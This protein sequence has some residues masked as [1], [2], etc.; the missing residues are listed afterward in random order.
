MKKLVFS[1]LGIVLATTLV[2]PKAASQGPQD[3]LV[4]ARIRGETERR[5][6][7]L[8]EMKEA[9]AELVTLAQVLSE[10]VDAEDGFR[11]SAKI[12]ENS[13]KVE[14]L[15]KQIDDLAKKIKRRAQGR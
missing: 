9:T 2:L 8:A 1:V 11:T 10:A 5:E 14:K 12:V 6:K 15:A 7:S 13:D 4:K 3:M